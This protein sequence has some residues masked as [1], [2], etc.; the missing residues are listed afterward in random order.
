MRANLM[1][2]GERT[3]SSRDAREV[4]SD[5]KIA[6]GILFG[7]ENSARR[8]LKRVVSDARKSP[9]PSISRPLTRLSC[10]LPSV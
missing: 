6:G 2:F 4:G 10:L 3:G 1:A 8:E 9:C 7:T 5:E